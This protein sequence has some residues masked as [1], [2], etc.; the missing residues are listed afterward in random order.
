M[1]AWLLL[2]KENPSKVFYAYT[3]SIAWA[4]LLSDT[5]PD[6]FR[7]IFS[8]GSKQDHL[9]DTENDYHAVVFRDSMPPDYSNGSES[10]LVAAVGTN[11]KIGLLIH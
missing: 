2:A 6:N 4:K 9:I 5:K 1:R 10:D 8:F 11:K 3:K 7:F